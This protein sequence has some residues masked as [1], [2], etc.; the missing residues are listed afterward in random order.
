VPSSL[1]FVGLVVLW[2]LILVPIVARRRQVV[3]RPGR[4]ARAGRVLQR[5]ARR[6]GRVEEMDEMELDKDELND[7]GP[8]ETGAEDA[9]E[10]RADARDVADDV[11]DDETDPADASDATDG[12]PAADSALD[13]DGRAAAAAVKVSRRGYRRGRGGYDPEAAELAASARYAFR[14]RVVLTLLVAALGTGIVAA[15]G[16]PV[17]WYLHG[18]IDIALVGYL[19]Y[20][21]RQVRLEDEIRFRRAARLAGTRFAHVGTEPLTPP[22]APTGL[23]DQPEEPAADPVA[24]QPTD[25]EQPAAPALPPLP[26]AEVPGRPRGT[27]VVGPDDEDPALHSLDDQLPPRY[28]RAAG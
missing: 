5:P 24:E 17:V 23:D 25:P 11:V 8:E 12:D 20:L 10:D 21:R 1:I 7:Q 18:A 15:F 3:P 9:P 19:I 13:G 6:P 28:R 16:L 26:R 14:Q 4:A 27:M 22:G 2:L